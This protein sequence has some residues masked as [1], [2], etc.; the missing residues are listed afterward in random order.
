MRDREEL[1][2]QGG[3]SLSL[4][5]VRLSHS[6]WGLPPSCS[7]SSRATAGGAGGLRLTRLRLTCVLCTNPPHCRTPLAGAQMRGLRVG[8]AGQRP[9]SGVLGVA[10]SGAAVLDSASLGTI[11][12]SVSL[13]LGAPPPAGGQGQGDR[14]VSRLGSLAT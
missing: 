8:Q 4:Q 14:P 10:Q 13:S 6:R 1:G 5:A 2:R 9:E 12:E 7:G 11:G 3:C